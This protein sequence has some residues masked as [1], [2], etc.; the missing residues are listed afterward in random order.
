MSVCSS[1]GSRAFSSSRLDEHIPQTMSFLSLNDDVLEI[2]ISFI[3]SPDAWRLAQTCRYLYDAAVCQY[4]SIVTINSWR[5]LIGFSSFVLAEP[6]RKLYIKALEVSLRYSQEYSECIPA[7]IE[8]LRGAGSLRSLSIEDEHDLLRSLPSLRSA[9][10]AIPNLERIS[11]FRVGS[12]FLEVLTHMVSRPR[13]LKVSLFPYDDEVPFWHALENLTGCLETLDF[14]PIQSL[15][16]GINNVWPHV[17]SLSVRLHDGCRSLYH[18]VRAFPNVRRFKLNCGGVY[19]TR[20]HWASL[21]EVESNFP[22]TLFSRVRRLLLHEDDFGDPDGLSNMVLHML[23]HTSPV[24]LSFSTWRPRLIPHLQDLTPR[25]KYL[26][27]VTHADADT[28]HQQSLSIAR[29]LHGLQ[30]T[31]LCICYHSSWMTEPQCDLARL[32]GLAQQ[33]AA[34][35]PTLGYVGFD[36]SLGWRDER[37]VPRWFCVVSRDGD[38]P[39]LDLLSRG[40]G[41]ELELRL[42]NLGSS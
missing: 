19:D 39:Q 4:L 14:S 27:V 1:T 6:S 36:S 23:R 13:Y 18:L 16:P 25:L 24:V 32:L 17:H 30:L 12:K 11:Y 31:A 22:F 29:D 3:P 37:R 28:E 21:D 41:E 2:I 5:Q 7:F 34:T 15:N 40:Q 38:V 9:L 33:V 26:K 8:V 10:A 35:L 20:P 42:Y